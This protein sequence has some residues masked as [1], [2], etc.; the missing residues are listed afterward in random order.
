RRTRIL[1]D[2]EEETILSKMTGEYAKLRAPFLTALYTGC[3][4]GEMFQL[5][6][7]DINFD[8]QYIHFRA[9]TTKTGEARSAPL[10]ERALSE[11]RALK[12]AGEASPTIFG[13]TPQS[14]YDG[15]RKLLDSLD[16]KDVSG[17]H[18]CRHSY[19]TRAA[20]AR[21]PPVYVKDTMGHKEFDM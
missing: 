1:S 15:L 20:K 9:E 8:R 21:I 3:R 13:L 5:T 2:E 17:F 6:W 10:I 4:R 18:V 12:D 16:L 11:L 7:D 19:A 14:A